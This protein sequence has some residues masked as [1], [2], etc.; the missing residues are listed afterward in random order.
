MK[1]VDEYRDP[2]LA[3]GLAAEIRSLVTPGEVVHVMEI[4]G[5]HTHAIYRHGL[6]ELLP[7]EIEFVHGPGCPVCVIP[8]GRV[9]DAITIAEAEGVTLATFGDMLRV[10]GGRGSLLEAMARGADVRMVYSPLDALELARRE[11][12]RHVCFFAIGF[13]TTAPATAVTLLRARAEALPNFSV[14]C[15]H[16]LIEPPLRA[17]LE[18]PGLR[19]DAFIGPGHVSS[20]I[21]SDAYRFIPEE[22][23]RPIVVTAFEPVDLLQAV[24]MLLR[25]RADGRCEVENQYTRVVRPEGNARALAS[26]AAT[27]ETRDDFE[28]RGLGV[29][30][31]S[32]LQLREEL[33]PFDAERLFALPG[34]RIEDPKACRCGEVLTGQ[35]KPWECGVFGTACTPERPLGTCMVSSEGA[36]AAF[37]SYGRLRRPREE[38]FVGA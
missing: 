5:G 8:M 9:D 20:V 31:R 26:I 15:N 7:P 14:F 12:E 22:F 37:F 18:T 29:L 17:I 6:E 34:A 2:T 10:P 25:Q 1:Y 33:A 13:E 16:V 24:V 21:G 19:V 38:A 4:C 27:M 28:W 23:G 11:P 30:P 32:A 3:H 36:C 35:I